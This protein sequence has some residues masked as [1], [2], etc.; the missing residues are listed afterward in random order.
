[1]ADF[2]LENVRQRL[3]SP[4]GMMLPDFGER[5]AVQIRFALPD[6][7]DVVAF[8][9]ADPCTIVPVS[10]HSSVRGDDLLKTYR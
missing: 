10:V 9:E 1:M 5:L 7:L 4:D 6:S 3:Q 8:G 2:W